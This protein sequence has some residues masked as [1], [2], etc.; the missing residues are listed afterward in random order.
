MD[1]HTVRSVA[2]NVWGGEESWVQGKG[3]SYEAKSVF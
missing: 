1:L 2:H 3:T